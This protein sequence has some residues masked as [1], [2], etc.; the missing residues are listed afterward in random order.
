MQM[1]EERLENLF[2]HCWAEMEGHREVGWFEERKVRSKGRGHP[3][4]PRSSSSSSFLPAAIISCSYSSSRLPKR[5][6]NQCLM[7][8]GIPLSQQQQGPTRSMPLFEREHHV[9]TP[10]ISQ[11]S[12]AAPNPTGTAWT[13]FNQPQALLFFT[14]IDMKL[15][16]P[17]E[18]W[19]FTATDFDHSMPT[20]CP[21]VVV[22][23][24]QA[25]HFFNR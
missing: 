25:R 22:P 23:P 8:A 14:L 7:A 13:T 11:P 9:R 1:Y 17:S 6:S 4:P 16:M 20:P 21:T 24:N 2:L 5:P 18:S 12:C 3:A 15:A 19:A 10:T